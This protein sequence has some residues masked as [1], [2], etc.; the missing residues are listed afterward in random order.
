[1]TSDRS[2]RKALPVELAVEELETCAGRQFDPGV[3]AALGEV[4]RFAQPLAA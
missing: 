2:Y 3:V 4:I 1:M